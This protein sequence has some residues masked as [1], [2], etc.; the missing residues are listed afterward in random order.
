MRKVI[1]RN[2]LFFIMFLVI[3]ILFFKRYS[4]LQIPIVSR[5]DSWIDFHT[6]E[7]VLEQ[8]WQIGRASC[9]ERV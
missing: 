9:R 3:G 2:V 6:E 7:S 4:Y 5:P 1:R 8:T